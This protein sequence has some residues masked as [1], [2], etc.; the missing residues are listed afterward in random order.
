MTFNATET[1]RVLIMDVRQAAHGLNLSSASRVYFVNPVWRPDIEAQAIKRAH[2][3]GQT[4]PVVVETLVLQGTLE[5]KMTQRQKAM[6]WTEH[7]QAKDIIDDGFMSSIIKEAE[8]IP[9]SDEEGEGYEQVAFL[10]HPIQ[11]FS[12]PRQV[13]LLEDDP[14]ADLIELSGVGPA[15]RQKVV[16]P[17]IRD[18]H[19]P[20]PSNAERGSQRAVISHELNHEIYHEANV[21]RETFYTKR[22]RIVRF[23][24]DE[25]AT[26]IDDGASGRIDLEP[27]LG[28]RPAPGESSSMVHIPSKRSRSSSDED[29]PTDEENENESGKDYDKDDEGPISELVRLPSLFGGD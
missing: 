22:R 29:E 15:R 6:T 23:A 8:L 26:I 17:P 13:G 4:R 1:F 18:S 20:T 21:V 19:V 9:I 11:L 3:I 10:N 7:E 24:L 5:E 25:E 16:E 28:I 12:Q 2:R 27:A 14:D